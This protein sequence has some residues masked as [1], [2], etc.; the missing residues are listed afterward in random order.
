MYRIFLREEQLE[1]Y[2]TDKNRKRI[3]TRNDQNNKS[4]NLKW[5]KE[6]EN[7]LLVIKDGFNWD[8]LRL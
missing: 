5:N 7:F 3:W 6:N 4:K 1:M 2:T 8:N